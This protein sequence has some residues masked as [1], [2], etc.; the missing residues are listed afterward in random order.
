MPRPRAALR[1]HRHVRALR[2]R[3]TREG[4]PGRLPRA[5]A[6]GVGRSGELERVEISAQH[7]EAKHDEA[8]I[9]A[10]LDGQDHFEANKCAPYRT[11]DL[12]P[13]RIAPADSNER[14]PAEYRPDPRAAVPRGEAPQHSRSLTD[15]EEPTPAG[16][17]PQLTLHQFPD[18]GRA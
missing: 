6:C 17:Q 2:P 11:R 18:H 3:T 8:C 13:R 16:A 14:F 9:G 4:N 1:S 12:D 5:A 10:A 15:D 7:G